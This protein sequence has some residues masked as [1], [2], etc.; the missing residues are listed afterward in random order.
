MTEEAAAVKGVIYRYSSTADGT[1]RIVIELDE[2]QTF[3]FHQSQMGLGVHVAVAR[4]AEQ[5]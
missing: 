2:L 5:E 4:L 1:L 3:I